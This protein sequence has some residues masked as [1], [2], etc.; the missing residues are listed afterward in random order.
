MNDLAWLDE[1]GKLDPLLKG[2]LTNADVRAILLQPDGKILVAGKF[3]IENDANL[4]LTRLNSNGTRDTT[5]T[6]L[7]GLGTLG[8]SLALQPDGK[9]LLGHTFGVMRLNTNGA[10]DVKFGPQNAA[11]ALGTDASGAAALALNLDG[12][13]LVGA[14]RVG[15]STT[16]RL[17]DVAPDDY[18]YIFD[19]Y[20]K[21]SFFVAQEV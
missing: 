3:Q 12:H 10:V 7:N 2:P 5:F 13:L 16:Q 19:T 17:Q 4:C 8:L 6:S 18:D 20:V 9:I 1:D 21:G 11:G 14:V 15:V